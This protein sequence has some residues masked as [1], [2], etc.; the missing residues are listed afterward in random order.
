MR[1]TKFDVG[2]SVLVKAEVENICI[3]KE[4]G[5]HYDLIIRDCLFVEKGQS[6]KQ[7]V[8]GIAEKDIMGFTDY[9]NDCDEW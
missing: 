6:N 8:S 4:H 9:K 7:H 2:E 5:I 3:D 1:T